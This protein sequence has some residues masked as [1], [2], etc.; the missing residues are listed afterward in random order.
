MSTPE[1][2]L[3]ESPGGLAKA[4]CHHHGWHWP[5]GQA[6]STASFVGHRERGERKVSA[7][8][9]T[10]NTLSDRLCVFG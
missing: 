1:N 9:S 3:S 7:H 2:H 5:L 6:A 10:G 8:Y 4:C